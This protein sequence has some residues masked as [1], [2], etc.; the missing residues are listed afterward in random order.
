MEEVIREIIDIKDEKALKWL[1]LLRESIH[2]TAREKAFFLLDFASYSPE[3][4]EKFIQVLER[5]KRNDKE[6]ER[7]YPREFARRKE[8][9]KKAWNFLMKQ[10]KSYLNENKR[11]KDI[12]K[13]KK[14]L[15]ELF[16]SNN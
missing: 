2:F 6:L 13:I 12:A 1:Q 7:K 4:I 11:K 5:V 16:R 9:S 8:E 14:E 15:A 3:E 10:L